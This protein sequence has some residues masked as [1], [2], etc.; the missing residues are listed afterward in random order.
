MKTFQLASWCVLLI[1]LSGC[2]NSTQPTADK[3]LSA[4]P[5]FR[6][7]ELQNTSTGEQ[8]RF[9][10]KIVLPSHY[11]E[12]S[13]KSTLVPI[14]NMLNEPE[15]ETTMFFYG[16]HSNQQRPYDVAR[17]VWKHNRLAEI[18]YKQPVTPQQR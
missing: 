13:V 10:L 15:S 14:S 3:G 18:D 17:V 4:P 16:P 7:V 6:I 5:E 9:S 2:G 1:I 12:N 8:K 11:S